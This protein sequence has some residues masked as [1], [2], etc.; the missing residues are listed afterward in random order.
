MGVERLLALLEIMLVNVVLSGDNAVVIA[1]ASRNLQPAQQKK[2]IFWGTF[3]AVVLR[4]GLTFLAVW[5]LDIPLVQAIGGILLLY[6]AFKLLINGDEQSHGKQSSSM[7]QAIQTIIV[8]DVIMSLDNVVAVAATAKGDWLLICIGLAV[9]IPLIIWCSQLLTN[10]MKRYPVIVWMGAG[11]L[12]YSAGEMLQSD[13]WV[14]GFLEPWLADKPYMLP[15]I[16]I[17]VVWGVGWVSSMG[18][19]RRMNKTSGDA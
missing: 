17:L 13:A 9:S 14:Q 1:M 11:L 16:F 6:I 7:G 4:L 5:L 8:A 3:G 2:A 19:R 10:L 15:V 18:S 12:G